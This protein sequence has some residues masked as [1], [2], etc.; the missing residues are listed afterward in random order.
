MIIKLFSYIHISLF[1]SDIKFALEVVKGNTH[2]PP[3]EQLFFYS[4]F[5]ER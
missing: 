2:T 5:V 4:S 3:A 1:K